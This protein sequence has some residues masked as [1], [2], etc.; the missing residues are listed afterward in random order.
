MVGRLISIWDGPIS[1]AMLVSGRV[2]ETEMVYSFPNNIGYHGS[3][4]N[5]CKCLKGS[6]YC[7]YAPCMVY[8][9]FTYIYHKNQPN[10]GKYTIHGAFG[11]EIQPFF[12][13]PWSY[14]R[15]SMYTAAKETME[16]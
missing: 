15:R 3:V 1:G 14:G 11:L 7:P 10:V 13:E 16:S 12:T 4:E 5:G 8:L 6:Y 9:I 2:V